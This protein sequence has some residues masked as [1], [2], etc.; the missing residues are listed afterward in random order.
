MDATIAAIRYKG[1]MQVFEDCSN[2]GLT[3]HVYCQQNR[4]DEKQF[5]YYQRRIRAMLSA[6][7]E[8]PALPEGS[9]GI[10][11]TSIE[12]QSKQ[13]QIV[14][15]WL[16]GTPQTSSATISFSVTCVRWLP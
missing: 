1:W 15:L 9:S 16:S 7:V 6:Q 11:E 13:T 2:S 10:V 14:K 8:H 4:I 12:K 3:K 5:Y